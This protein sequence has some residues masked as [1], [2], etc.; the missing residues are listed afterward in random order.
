MTDQM[1]DR[2]SEQ[3]YTPV[4]SETQR[5]LDFQLVG[6]MINLCRLTNQMRKNPSLKPPE[7]ELEESLL[8]FAKMFRNHVLTD[9]RILMLCSTLYQEQNGEVEGAYD[10]VG[11]VDTESATSLQ[12][13]AQLCGQ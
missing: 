8:A 6:K 11:D 7:I 9:S 13:L 10:N 1:N 4:E 3:N 12:M 2:F 5:Y